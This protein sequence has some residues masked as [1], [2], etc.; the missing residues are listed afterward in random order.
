MVAEGHRLRHLQMGEAGQGGLG[1]LF[2]QR[3]QGAKVVGEQRVDG[4]QGVAQPQANVGGHLIVARAAGVQAL[5]GIADEGGEALFDIQVHIFVVQIPTEF[6]AF[7][8]A[9]DLRHAAFDRGQIGG[10]DDGLPGQHPGMGER[11]ADVLRGHA[12]VKKYRGRVTLDQV[13][14]RFGEAP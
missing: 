11:A 5:A 13:R 4:V 1:M 12:L 10:A 6:A 7:D 2:G 8:F 3:E 14:D 9:G